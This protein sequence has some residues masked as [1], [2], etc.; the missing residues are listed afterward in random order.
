MENKYAK[1]VNI[2]GKYRFFNDSN[3]LIKI[4]QEELDKL[5]S[6]ISKAV[7]FIK[8]NQEEEYVTGNPMLN[9]WAIDNLLS[10]LEGSDK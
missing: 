6:I 4:Q 2:N 5:G 3:D 7:K 8:E 10:I 9:Y 1:F